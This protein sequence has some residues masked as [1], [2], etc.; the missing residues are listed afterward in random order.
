MIIVIIIISFISGSLAHIKKL[1]ANY[2]KTKQIN[3][4]TQ[5][6]GSNATARTKIM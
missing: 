1:Y 5:R 3:S 4:Q 2:T 6:E